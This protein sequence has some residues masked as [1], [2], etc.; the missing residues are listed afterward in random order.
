MTSKRST[1]DPVVLRASL[2]KG[3]YTRVAMK[4]GVSCSVVRRVAIGK[5]RS[6]RIMQALIDECRRI[7][8]A[9]EK[10]EGAA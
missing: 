5:A 8:R 3:I 7:E 10:Q 9:I 1:L 2:Y 6:E 4:L